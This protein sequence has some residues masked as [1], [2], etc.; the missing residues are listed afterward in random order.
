VYQSS[1]CTELI[2]V[3]LTTAG[4]QHAVLL[5]L[6]PSGHRLTC[7]AANALS[8]TVTQQAAAALSD[9]D[10]TFAGLTDNGYLRIHIT[11]SIPGVGAANGKM[12]PFKSG[13]V[14]T[15]DTGAFTFATLVGLP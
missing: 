10:F 11:V 3:A 9:Q 12:L 4:R 5:P 14:L 13:W 15:E 8:S 1:K 2:S 6:G 7:E